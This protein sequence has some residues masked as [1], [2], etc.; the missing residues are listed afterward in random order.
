MLFGAPH[1]RPTCRMQGHELPEGD[2]P[3]G[4]HTVGRTAGLDGNLAASLTHGAL[5][6]WKAC[7]SGLDERGPLRSRH[8]AAITESMAPIE[9]NI[10]LLK[11]LDEARQEVEILIEALDY[12]RQINCGCSATRFSE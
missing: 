2:R 11:K 8:L 9:Q 1:R 6:G 7:G 12:A 3:L 5:S 10:L 4:Q